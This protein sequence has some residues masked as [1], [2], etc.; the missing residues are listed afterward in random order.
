MSDVAT[1][2]QNLVFKAAEPTSPGERINEQ[3][4][5]AERR[6]KKYGLANAQSRVWRA[7]RKR[8]GAKTYFEILTAF[9]AW[10]EAEARKEANRYVQR[11]EGLKEA[12]LQTDSDFHSDTAAALD[13]AISR[14]GR[15][16]SPLDS[17]AA[18]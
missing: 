10:A 5:R 2:A 11:L 12:L 18:E 9:D 8:A 16:D 15:A 4:L 14:L 3:M 13:Y 7:W 1:M 17:G 6:L